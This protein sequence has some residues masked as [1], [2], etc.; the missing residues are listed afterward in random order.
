MTV[1]VLAVVVPTGRADIAGVVAGKDT[2]TVTVRG[3]QSANVAALS[4]LILIA[5]VILITDNAGGL[6]V[7]SRFLLT[8][9]NIRARSFDVKYVNAKKPR[10]ES[11][12][13]PS[14]GSCVLLLRWIGDDLD[15]VVPA[16]DVFVGDV[17][18][19]TV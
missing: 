16:G 7:W 3:V 15:E 12:M 19:L 8:T 5:H 10:P 14:R 4:T 2:R 1:A 6:L 13:L 9:L 11:V 18:R 17:V